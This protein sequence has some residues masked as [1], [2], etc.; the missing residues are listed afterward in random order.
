MDKALIMK[1][2]S[3]PKTARSEL[4]L[5][6]GCTFAV[7]LVQ[8]L[9]A[10]TRSLWLD[11]GL[12]LAR[13]TRS[14]QDIL[15][16]LLWVQGSPRVDDHPPLYFLL[17]KAWSVLGGQ[18]VFTYRLF[19]AFAAVLLVPLTYVLVRR[20]FGHGAAI[21]A[22]FMAALCP[23][24]LWFGQEVRMYAL[25]AGLSALS[26]YCLYRAITQRDVRFGLGW[27][28][29][30]GAA[31][32]SHYAVAGLIAGE[33]L[34]VFILILATLRQRRYGKPLIVS[35]GVLSVIVIVAITLFLHSR[36]QGQRLDG[37]VYDLLGAMLFGLN[38]ADPTAGLV[39][40]SF[41]ALIVLGAL[42]PGS[43]H[44]ASTFRQR[45]LL[46]AC[47]VSP[48]VLLVS[49]TYFRA[50]TVS[51][52]HLILVIPLLHALVAGALAA[53]W[54]Y[55]RRAIA[56]LAS[57]VGQLLARLVL[58]VPAVLVLALSFAPAAYGAVLTYTP[59]PTW[60]DDWRGMAE[61]VRNHWQE[62]DVFLVNFQTP[63]L[64][65]AEYLQGTP[66]TYTPTISLHGTPDQ[67]RATLAQRYRR[68]WYAAGGGWYPEA[69]S[70]ETD[71]LAGYNQR[72]KVSFPARS[73]ILDLL[74]FETHPPLV[75]EL[76]ASATPIDAPSNGP[77][78]IAGY[79][80]TPGS[81]YNPQP[82]LWLTLYWQRNDAA[83]RN[84][85]ESAVSVLLTKDGATWLDWLLPGVLNAAPAGWDASHYYV[86]QY[87][88]PVPPGLPALDYQLELSLRSGGKAEVQQ[89]AQLAVPSQQ[90]TC[91]I[92]IAR[93][94]AD[95]ALDR[96]Q[97]RTNG[98]TLISSEFS[99][100]VMPGDYLPV[101]LLW[102]LDQTERTGWQTVLTLDGFTS[103][104]L[105]SVTAPTGVQ[106][107]QLNQ[108]PVGEPVRDMRVL[109]VPYTAQPGWY[110]LS[111][112]RKADDQ[113]AV[114]STLLGLLQVK[115]YPFEPV[116]S[117]VP[118]TVTAHVGEF[119]LL[120]YGLYQPVTRDTLL[121]FHTYWRAESAPQQDGVL[122]LHLVAPD[123]SPG[124]QDDN[125]PMQGKRSTLTYR[126]GEGI[127]QVHRIIIA[128]NAPAGDYALYAG[129]YN[130]VDQQRW[131]AQQ[132]GGVAQ[133]NL[134]YLGKIHVP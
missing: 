43:Q 1:A 11:E 130:R 101:A 77:L 71:L 40:W 18:S 6:V 116:P 37:V 7:A 53:L 89:K 91:C 36:G 97:W 93:W 112:G 46:A 32:Y 119:S 19:S 96:A 106:G 55:G 15:S 63:D 48:I 90:L 133:D 27:L 9:T 69:H 84:D 108:W 82:N 45:I 5:V 75:S 42:L 8:L 50:N 83:A 12:T 100:A 70:F 107:A 65:L 54:A 121:E 102:K 117:N 4:W 114:Q 113:S 122:F 24:Y 52:R 115:P 64:V 81:L 120:G 87:Q 129:I 99:S 22:L 35:V 60:Q 51:F 118:V 85:A 79:Q 103:G 124:P 131:P 38:A 14:W 127:D 78:R 39:N 25:V 86:A 104:Q 26:V 62:G 41:F 2:P 13:V 125:P 29:V 74:L 28:C 126:A 31:M 17:L 72:E 68:V 33:M 59:S 73:S 98:V 58:A 110:R 76:P 57:R 30:T 61:Y 49:L 56:W 88:V 80:L 132:N 47:A 23:T 105:A 109:Q 10:V 66:I 34:A 95:P 111:V 123:G 67:V 16:G 94:P 134:V 3:K 92:R 21:A 128:S 44:P 20:L